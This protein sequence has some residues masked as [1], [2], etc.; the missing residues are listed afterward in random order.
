[1]PLACKPA[2]PT[3]RRMQTISRS[4][5]TSGAPLSFAQQR[6][7]FLDQF[8]PNSAT[9]NIPLVID[10]DGPLDAKAL[11]RAI[12][13]IVRRHDVLRTSFPSHRG[14]PYQEVHPAESFALPFTDLSALDADNRKAEVDLAITA[15]S[16][17]PFD[18][19][20]GPIFR[21]HLIRLT[22]VQH[23]SRVPCIT[24]CSM[25]GRRASFSRVDNAYQAF[26]DGEPSPLPDPPV[27]Y[28]D[29]AVWQREQL[30]G[31]HLE[32]EA[33]CWKD[34]LKTPP[35]LALPTDYRRPAIQTSEGARAHLTLPE[36][37]IRCGRCVQ[38]PGGSD[39]VHHAVDGLRDAPAPVLR[40]G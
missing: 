6:L 27:R 28:V 13:E 29:F 21:M 39:A 12:Y 8:T 32:R 34:H 35:R 11:R 16:R 40:P 23:A 18:L 25:H 1:M 22:D 17:R 38:P 30:R 15:E 33:R 4:L 3:F 20:N 9:Y 2:A 14:V 24:S 10:L 37:L 5:V 31:E 26:C 36:H 7:W 19:A